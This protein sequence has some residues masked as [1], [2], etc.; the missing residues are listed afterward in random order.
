LPINSS[1]DIAKIWGLKYIPE[2]ISKDEHKLLWQSINREP[3]L[4]DLK[5]RVQHYGWKYDYK[6]R[7]IDYSMYLGDLPDWAKGFAEKL[8]RCGHFSKIPDQLIVNEYQ[9]GQGIANHVDCEPCFGETI[10]S[11]SLGSEC[12]MDFINLESKEKIELMLHPRSL[13]VITGEARH[14]WT[15]GIAARK[16]DEFKGTKTERQL[17]ISLTF[18]NVITKPS[19]IFADRD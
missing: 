5:R 1:V 6:A 4:T 14:N 17:R 19:T 10:T 7:S 12:V 18:R 15:H 16:S 13:V 2:F 9:P 8:Y 11:L 3:W